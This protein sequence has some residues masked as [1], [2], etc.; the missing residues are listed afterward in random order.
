MRNL[1]HISKNGAYQLDSSQVGTPN[2]AS[3]KETPKLST[4]LKT[5]AITIGMLLMFPLSMSTL[6][7]GL[8]ES[9]EDRFH[10]AH[11]SLTEKKLDRLESKKLKDSTLEDF[12]EMER[13]QNKV[14]E[15]VSHINGEVTNSTPDELKKLKGVYRVHSKTRDS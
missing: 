3:K 4:K 5:T 2:N 12:K 9:A 1:Q 14:V 8:F 10:K 7:A 13:L 15:L 6:H 11:L